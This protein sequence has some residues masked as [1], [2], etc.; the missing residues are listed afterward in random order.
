M[1]TEDHTGEHSID[2]LARGLAS[3][4]VSRRKALR[5]MGGVLVGTALASVPG[6]ALTE[7]AAEAADACRRAS[8]CCTCRYIDKTTGEVIDSTCSTEVGRTCRSARID[9][10]FSQCR[11]R[12]EANTPP[13]AEP[14]V[15]Q[16][17]CEQ[18]RGIRFV[19][20]RRCRSRPC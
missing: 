18:E 10:F 7:R 15:F 5:L 16:Q 20:R 6:I 12:C 2:E 1:G 17:S 13:G 8:A 9:S 11:E 19:C 14:E 3:G 4:S